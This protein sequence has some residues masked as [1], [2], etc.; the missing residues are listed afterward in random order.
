MDTG[1]I[2]PLRTLDDADLSR[3]WEEERNAGRFIEVE[4]RDGIEPQPGDSFGLPG[5]ESRTSTRQGLADLE[6][7][8]DVVR[9]G[10]RDV[11]ADA[12]PGDLFSGRARQ[13]DIA[14][15]L[16]EPVLGADVPNGHRIA[17]DTPTG[18]GTDP[19]SPDG[20]LDIL[21]D[22]GLAPAEREA[23]RMFLACAGMNRISSCEEPHLA[24]RTPT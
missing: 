23:A 21:L 2:I 20:R 10:S 22:Q 18:R 13:L 15:A 4:G 19:D 14:D 3:L 5:V 24:V 1:E 11:P 9:N 8:R 16:H 17:S 6:R 12:G 7:Q